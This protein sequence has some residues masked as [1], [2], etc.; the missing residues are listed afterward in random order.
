MVN[1]RNQDGTKKNTGGTN[2]TGRSNGKS[3]VKSGYKKNERTQDDAQKRTHKWHP[4]NKPNSAYKKQP[5]NGA[6]ITSNASAQGN[7]TGHNRVLQ[8]KTN[9]F[10]I[11]PF[12]LFCAYHL[13][14]SSQNQYR[15]SNINEVANRFKVDIGTTRQI[16]K[17][18]GMDS[19]SLLDRDFDMALA[20][21][22][23]QVAPEGIDRTELG[24]NIF[25]DFLEAPIKK[26]D[27]KKIL[28]DDRKENA[29]TFRD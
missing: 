7:E 22:D 24:R 5:P 2:G 8:S 29:K 4:N 6:Q 3:R 16:L 25:E 28:E 17:E 19:A 26:R 14:I 27:W 23:I 13:G 12:E 1:K 21:L 9:T 20:Q 11:D 15:P 10:G 18:Y